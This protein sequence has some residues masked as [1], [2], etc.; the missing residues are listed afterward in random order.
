MFERLKLLY[1]QERITVDD[2]VNAV[3]RG[4]ITDGQFMQIT[5]LNYE[6]Y[7]RPNEVDEDE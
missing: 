4:W 5:T 2:L 1:E 7:I 6:D 3:K